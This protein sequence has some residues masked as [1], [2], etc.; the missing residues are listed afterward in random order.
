MTMLARLEVGLS[1]INNDPRTSFRIPVE[2]L[3]VE[4][5]LS[6]QHRQMGRVN[7]AKGGSQDLGKKAQLSTHCSLFRRTDILPVLN[8]YQ[9]LIGY[10]HRISP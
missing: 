4:K 3:A 6:A 9:C 1:D 5:V 10:P 7:C 2:R 8:G